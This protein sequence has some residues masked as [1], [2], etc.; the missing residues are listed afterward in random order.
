MRTKF[1]KSEVKIDGKAKGKSPED[2]D[3]LIDNDIVGDE[4]YSV[5][6]VSTNKDNQF[7]GQKP[8][9]FVNSKPIKNMKSLN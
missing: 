6:G 4:N 3:S 8:L 9:N 7:T 1:V 5:F 2:S